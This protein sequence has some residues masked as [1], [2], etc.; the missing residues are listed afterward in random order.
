M[1]QEIMID[2]ITPLASRAHMETRPIIRLITSI[3]LMIL[4]YFL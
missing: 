1:Q 2:I 3:V 4:F